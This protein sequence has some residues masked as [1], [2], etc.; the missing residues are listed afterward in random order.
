MTDVDLYILYSRF[1]IE[2]F[3]ISKL[4]YGST[5]FS[6]NAV[7]YISFLIRRF[8]VGLCEFTIDPDVLNYRIIL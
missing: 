1:R 2:I 5:E 8:Y 7:Q 3:M 4:I 6:D